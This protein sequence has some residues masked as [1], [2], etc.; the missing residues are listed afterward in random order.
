MNCISSC[1]SPDELQK[2]LHVKNNEHIRTQ[3]APERTGEVELE[4]KKISSSEALLTRKNIPIET[5]LFDEKSIKIKIFKGFHE[6]R[7]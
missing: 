5:Q 4:L 2:P 7:D 6:N 3:L 1:I